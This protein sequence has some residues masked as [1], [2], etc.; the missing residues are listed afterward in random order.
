[1]ISIV[2]GMTGAI[3]DD[4]LL[5]VLNLGSIATSQGRTPLLHP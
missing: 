1:M 5:M 4:H 2:E 3:A